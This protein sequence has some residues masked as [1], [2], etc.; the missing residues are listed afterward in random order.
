[1]QN[2]NICDFFDNIPCVA[3]FQV[4]VKNLYIF[5]QSINILF[6]KYNI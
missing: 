5:I 2:W 4:K 1:M 6:E 3:N